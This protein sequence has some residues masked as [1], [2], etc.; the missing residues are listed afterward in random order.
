M[1]E[2]GR[3]RTDIRNVLTVSEKPEVPSLHKMMV[4]VVVMEKIM[5]VILMFMVNEPTN[6]VVFRKQK[7]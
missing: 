4:V 1:D 3:M 6:S 5:I 7:K 2:L